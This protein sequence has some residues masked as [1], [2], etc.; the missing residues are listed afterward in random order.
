[1]TTKKKRRTAQE[2][3]EVVARW[4]ASG[5]PAE[6]FAKSEGCHPRTLSWWASRL[7]KS[8]KAASPSFAPV[9]VVDS[10]GSTGSVAIRHDSGFTVTVSEGT[11]AAVLRAAL[12]AVRAC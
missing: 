12:S 8:A 1:M 7:G 3:S 5:K 6:A 11:D 2:W 9:V 10:L 4:R